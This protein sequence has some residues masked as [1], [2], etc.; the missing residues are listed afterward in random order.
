MVGMIYPQPPFLKGDSM[1]VKPDVRYTPDEYLKMERDA[2]CKS[3]YFNGEIF[4]MA[5]ASR[6]H[7]LITMSISSRLYQQ[8]RK[9]ECEV[10]AN[11]MRVKVSSTGLYS[12]PD[13]VVVCSPPLFDDALSD[14]LLNPDLIIEVL[15]E[16][17]EA[18]DRGIKF[19]NYRALP[20]L[21]EYVLVHQDT[22]HVEHYSRQS[23][24]SWRF[25]EYFKPDD[26]FELRSIGCELKL[27]DIYEK[28][29]MSGKENGRQ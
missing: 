17:T 18:Y 21:S 10:Y 13:I 24:S 28:V 26:G 16:S 14:S 19:Q 11:D 12:Y 29:D 23:D 25:L 9:K 22:R 7:N 5:G 2:A 8:L 3:E 27:E 20:S 4:A 1:T 15:S 6:K